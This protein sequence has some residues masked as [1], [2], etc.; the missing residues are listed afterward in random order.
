MW[1]TF[2]T[3]KIKLDPRMSLKT[4]E[5]GKRADCPG[6]PLPLLIFPQQRRETGHFEVVVV[7]RPT[8]HQLVRGSLTILW[9]LQSFEFTT[10]MVFTERGE[11]APNWDE[12]MLCD[13]SVEKWCKLIQWLSSL[14]HLLPSPGTANVVWQSKIVSES[15][16]LGS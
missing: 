14:R 2:M 4:H 11:N 16:D 12:F 5:A 3:I 10:I 9:T 6:Q 8:S 15:L 13:F 7:E 1:Q